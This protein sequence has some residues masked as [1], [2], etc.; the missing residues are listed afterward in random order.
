MK[1]CLLAVCILLLLSVGSSYIFIPGIIDINEEII[2]RANTQ[3]LQRS[4]LDQS[5]WRKWWPAK[6][7]P[8]AGADLT[9]DD[10]TYQFQARK[11]SSI[12]LDIENKH[13]KAIAALHIL[14]MSPDSAR[15]EWNSKMASSYNPWERVQAYFNSRKLRKQLSSILES[16][17]KYYSDP[18]NMYEADIRQVQVTDSILVST[19]GESKNLPSVEFIYGLIDELKKYIARNNA[20]ETGF[21]MLNIT[22]TD[23]VA[24]LTRVAIPVNKRLAPSGNISYRW[25][26]GGGKILVTEVRG[27]P[28]AISS[29][30]H[31]VENYIRDYRRIAPAIPFYS[32]QTDRRKEPDTS[33]WVTKIYYPVM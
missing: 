16:A 14:P 10:V 15:L 24:Y 7:N 23:S 26:M 22:T 18:R 30:F 2:V 3:G 25:M 6:N 13:I 29:T 8:D 21:P 28:W 5:S 9:I 17:K 4:L 11:L 1:K 12:V 19:Y 20:V 32:L 33:K 27:G 31:Q